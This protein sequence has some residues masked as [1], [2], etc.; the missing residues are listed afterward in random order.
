V[1]VIHEDVPIQLTGAI[2][3]NL[4]TSGSL[5]QTAE[6]LFFSGPDRGEST[7]VKRNR[8]SKPLNSNAYSFSYLPAK[9]YQMCLLLFLW[10]GCESYTDR[11]L[12]GMQARIDLQEQREKE[13]ATKVAA[14]RTSR[15][16]VLRATLP[17][18]T[19]SVLS[20]DELQMLAERPSEGKIAQDNT[21]SLKR[22]KAI[23][24]VVE[25]DR[26]VQKATTELRIQIRVDASRLATSNPDVRPVAEA[27]VGR[28]AEKIDY[29]GEL[30]YT[31]VG[32]F[33]WTS[34]MSLSQTRNAVREV[35]ISSATSDVLEARVKS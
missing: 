13:D 32:E 31:K 16:A 28:S 29:L 11:S 24:K 3:V 15:I 35:M 8:S 27:I 2:P 22:L 33:G 17:T 4:Q 18:E 25:R 12:R 6:V 19:L 10:C 14:M 9:K 7:M 26:E 30:Y 23:Y 1:T 5:L 21:R 34:G 20:P